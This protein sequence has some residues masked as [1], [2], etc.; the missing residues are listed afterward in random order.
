MAKSDDQIIRVEIMITGDGNGARR[1]VFE[2]SA[3]ATDVTELMARI[4]KSLAEFKTVEWV[5]DYL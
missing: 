3:N 2:A 5:T 1:R 4:G